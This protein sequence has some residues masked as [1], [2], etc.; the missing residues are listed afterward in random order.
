VLAAGVALAA[1]AIAACVAQAPHRPAPPEPALQLWTPG[2]VRWSGSTRVL[3]FSIEN[4]TDHTVEVEEPDPRHAGVVIYTGSG[5]DRACSK[6]PEPGPAAGEPQ[7]LAPGEGRGLEID[8][9]AACGRIPPGEYRYELV[10]DA[11]PAGA[12]PPFRLLPRNGQ[13]LVEAEPYC[14]PDR[15]G[16]GFGGGA[17]E[18]GPDLRRTGCR[19]R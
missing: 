5:N 7:R 9:G 13:V 1:A 10:Y 15:G 6:D 3:R 12:G 17:P 14:P 2:L 19:A 18:G 4:R 8:L 11:P 16:L